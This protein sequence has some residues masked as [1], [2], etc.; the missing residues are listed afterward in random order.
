M[1]FFIGTSI[2]SLVIVHLQD[3]VAQ[4]D[5]TSD[6]FK[7]RAALLKDFLIRE[8]MSEH[9]IARA[10]AHMQRLWRLQR[11]ATG[12]EVATFIPRRLYCSAVSGAMGVLI[13]N[14]FVIPALSAEFKEAFTASLRQHTYLNGEDIFRSGQT[15]DRLRILVSGGVSLVAADLLPI[16]GGGAEQVD[17]RNV[18]SQPSHGNVLPHPS[19]P[20][21]TNSFAFG[22]SDESIPFWHKP[23]PSC[24]TH[25]RA[26]QQGSSVDGC[27]NEAV[28][29]PPR[30]KPVRRASYS[31]LAQFALTNTVP[32]QQGQQPYANIID[33]SLGECE[34]LTRGVFACTARANADSVM[35]EISFD[36]FWRLLAAHRME[37]I[38][39]ELLN[40]R[41]DA[42]QLTSTGAAVRRLNANLMSSKMTKMLSIPL[43]V[44]K[45]P[46][47]VHPDSSIAL[48]WNLLSLIVG[49]YV[50]FTSPFFAAFSTSA[51]T[52][53]PIVDVLVVVFSLV[54][55]YFH[56]RVFA[57]K[58]DGQVVSEP[59]KFAAIYLKND[60]KLDAIGAFPVALLLLL[61]TG[62]QQVYLVSRCLL[63]L[64]LRKAQTNIDH[65]V[66]S[67]EGSHGIRI[68]DDHLR[69]A[70][71]C[72]LIWYLGHVVACAYCL[73]G[74]L[75]MKAG[76]A[77]WI[78]AN[79]FE[80]ETPLGI[81]LRSYLWSMYTIVTVGYGNI[82]VNSNR[83]RV[84][85][86]VLMIIGA[87]MCNATIA[88]IFSSII[89]AQDR[90]RGAARFVLRL[91]KRTSSRPI[92]VSTDVHS[93][94]RT[95]TVRAI[96]ST[97]LCARP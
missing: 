23:T 95:A 29:T 26:E 65:V 14:L 85:A 46:W 5:V 42:L 37:A 56:L 50:S 71:A 44:S 66:S 69:V 96:A 84:F 43:S 11:G 36:A 68:H 32:V 31:D 77:S 81:Y 30:S 91:V 80:H 13:D 72:V 63:V 88:A 47:V 10:S 89:G 51:M 54:E 45:P 62:K 70:K 53:I 20:R 52:V 19:P 15:C 49:I 2:L 90:L 22:A 93:N 83:E 33:G 28:R 48:V 35:Y 97:R 7:S 40:E 3:I 73:L 16:P 6:I 25:P 75:E 64:R 57:V 76:E 59:T 74:E 4:L 92:C 86:S 39:V 21:R 8:G 60:L 82:S 55:I 94:P 12:S 78:T 1:F 38:F 34:F 41:L 79:K 17:D 87:V 18:P 9:F 67:L 58:R 61:A 27:D 24:S